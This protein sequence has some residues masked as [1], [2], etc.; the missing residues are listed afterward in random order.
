MAP[1]GHAHQDNHV[2]E[3]RETDW[4]CCHEQALVRMAKHRGEDLREEGISEAGYAGE[5]EEEYEI[6]DKENGGDDVQPVSIV[7]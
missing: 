5:K 1:D 4:K 6:E 3:S 7:G 2:Y